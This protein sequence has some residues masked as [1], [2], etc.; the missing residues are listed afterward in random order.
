MRTWLRQ[1]VAA[2]AQALSHLVKGRNGFLLNVFVVAVALALPVAG[3]TV[4]ENLRPVAKQL[5]VE[6][7]IS[8]FLKADLP[9]EQ[10]VALSSQIAKIAQDAHRPARLEFVPRENALQKL[11]DRTGIS[12]AITAL[13]SNPL[14]DAYVLRLGAFDDAQEAARIDDVAAQLKSLPGVELVQIDSA[15]IKRLA[16]IAHIL[17]IAILLLAAALGAV[18]V[19]VVFNTIRLQVL[20]QRDEIE[21]SRLLGAGDAYVA[22]PFYYTGA[23]LGLCAGLAA[24]AMVAAALPPMNGA[25]TELARLYASEFRL[26][27]LGVAISGLLLCLS[28]ALGVLGAL[29]SVRRHLAPL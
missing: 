20:N 6:P 19:A 5:T 16:A 10:A 21:V 18:V 8:L 25:I 1:H 17:R 12:D 11:N 4:L 23:L 24:L 9:R 15:W 29:L 3:M 27:P 13:G 22:R 7:E 28:T 2:M 26:A 14:P